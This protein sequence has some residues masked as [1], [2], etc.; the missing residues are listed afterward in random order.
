MIY[1]SYHSIP[2]HK[3]PLDTAAS[4]RAK[5]W[6]SSVPANLFE[7]PWF[8]DLSDLKVVQSQK[9]AV[10]EY[11][12]D[13][14]QECFFRVYKNMTA[15]GTADFIYEYMRFR[16]CAGSSPLDHWVKSNLRAATGTKGQILIDSLLEFQPAGKTWQCNAKLLII[17][18]SSSKRGRDK[19]RSSWAK[20]VMENPEAELIFFTSNHDND[21]QE[22]DVVSSSIDASDPNFEF[23]QSLAMYIWLYQNCP[24]AQFVLKT[25]EDTFVNVVKILLLVNQEQYA[26]NRL[27]GELIQRAR[28]AW[29][30]QP[31][32]PSPEV[33]P[34][35]RRE[36]PYAKYP[37]FL[38]G[39]LYYNKWSCTNRKLH[40][41]FIFRPIVHHHGGS[42]ATNSHGLDCDTSN[43]SSSSIFYG[44]RP[45]CCPHHEDRS[46]LIFLL[47]SSAGKYDGPL[48]I[49]PIWSY[50][51]HA[52][53]G[54]VSAS[55]KH[56]TR[57]HS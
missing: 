43:T 55:P 38:K 21:V 18:F 25:R 12:L 46:P 33:H 34:V 15:Y 3:R 42:G 10:E 48:R 24:R 14:V 17:V 19:V 51:W 54:A 44:P 7:N 6:E 13:K 57:H 4:S 45:A 49:C 16:D 23:K 36:W 1:Q 37:P 11:T 32:D 52:R 47:L 2:Q 28:P 26:A 50:S 27:Y 30:D 53:R 8:S 9:S 41:S 39:K 5:D 40:L 31:V 22:S 56:D 20:L 29:S 35:S